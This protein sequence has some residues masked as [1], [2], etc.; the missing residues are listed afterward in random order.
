MRQRGCMTRFPPGCRTLTTRFRLQPA[1]VSCSSTTA[2]QLTR[3]APR[4]ASPRRPSEEPPLGSSA[5]DG[6]ARIAQKA[7]SA[8]F[9]RSSLGARTLSRQSRP[10][11]SSPPP[12]AARPSRGGGGVPCPTYT[13]ALSGRTS[14][15]SGPLPPPGRRISCAPTRAK[16]AKLARASAQLSGALVFK[17]HQTCASLNSRLKGLPGPVSRRRRRGRRSRSP[18]AAAEARFLQPCSTR[19][20]CRAGSCTSGGGGALLE[21]TEVFF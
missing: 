9:S 12:R 21:K 1:R 13:P 10:G 8:A 16:P 6:K 2:L 17:A 5:Q 7:R 11:T 15:L 18:D 4:R 19:V 14:F 20:L 3:D